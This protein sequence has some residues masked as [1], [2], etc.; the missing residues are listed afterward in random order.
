MGGCQD[1][2]LQ[3]DLDRITAL[4]ASECELRLQT[5]D[6]DDP[7]ASVRAYG[8]ESAS[9]LLARQA[10]RLGLPAAWLELEFSNEL[11]PAECVLEEAGI[12]EVR[13]LPAD[14][15]VDECWAGG[16]GASAGRGGWASEASS[17]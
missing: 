15:C 16:D 5:D 14:P 9:A 4:E 8:L 11:V 10:E 7:I 13:P 12:M 3:E 6:G 17:D 1:K 2:P